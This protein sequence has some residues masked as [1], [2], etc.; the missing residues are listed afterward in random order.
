M[1]ISKKLIR[2]S[3][4]A[5]LITIVFASTCFANSSSLTD[6]KHDCWA[7]SPDNGLK[8]FSYFVSATENYTNSGGTVTGTSRNLFLYNY[9]SMNSGQAGFYYTIDSKYNTSGSTQL[10]KLLNSNYVNGSYW[11]DGTRTYYMHHDNNTQFNYSYASYSSR[12]E[13]STYY[14]LGD[15]WSPGIFTFIDTFEIAY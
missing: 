14:A 12:S 2:S 10:F 9:A 7:F 4:L 13:I 3:I 15:P 11:L 5:L 6:S 8:L 1:K